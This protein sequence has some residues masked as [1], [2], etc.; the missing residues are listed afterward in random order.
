M[1]GYVW[2]LPRWDWVEF[3]GLLLVAAWAV[4]YYRSHD[5]PEE[6]AMAEHRWVPY[7]GILREHA[8]S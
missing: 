5:P 4:W 8:G 7:A 2:G 6:M 1:S 3:A